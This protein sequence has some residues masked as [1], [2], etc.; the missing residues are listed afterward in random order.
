MR[1]F[2]G[3]SVWDSDQLKKELLDGHWI[4]VQIECKDLLSQIVWNED[5]KNL[6]WRKLLR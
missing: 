2:I 1:C 5:A 6:M 3:T 4:A